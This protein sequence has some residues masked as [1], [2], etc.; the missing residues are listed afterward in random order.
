M[1]V[2]IKILWKKGVSNHGFFI[3]E[4][5][6]V[7]SLPFFLFFHLPTIYLSLVISFFFFYFSSPYQFKLTNW[8]TIIIIFIIIIIIIIIIIL[9]GIL[10]KSSEEE[11]HSKNSSGMVYLYSSW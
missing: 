10:E 5:F 6:L 2:Y 9:T 11:F 4:M 1:D 7:V 8:I 3:F